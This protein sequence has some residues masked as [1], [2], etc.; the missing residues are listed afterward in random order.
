MVSQKEDEQ[1]IER[2]F[3]LKCINKIVFVSIF[4]VYSLLL[5]FK[6]KLDF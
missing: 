1:L 4:L 6:N 3:E 5:L 2:V